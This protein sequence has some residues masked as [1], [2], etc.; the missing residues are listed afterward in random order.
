MQNNNLKKPSSDS[1]DRELSTPK[2]A[3]VECFESARKRLKENQAK[4]KI[5]KAASSLSW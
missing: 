1:V 3:K 2:V 4:K 5:Y